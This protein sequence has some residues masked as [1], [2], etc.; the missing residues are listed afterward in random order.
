M[1]KTRIYAMAFA[2]PINV[3]KVLLIMKMAIII[4]ILFCFE[5]SA[6]ASAQTVTL[7]V[8]NAPLK[9]VL[10]RV[11][12]QTNYL[13]MLTSEVE[14]YVKSITIEAKDMPLNLFLT[15]ILGSQSAYY[16]KENTIFIKPDKEK[17]NNVI[18]AQSIIRGRVVDQLGNP[19]PRASVQV[20]ELKTVTL[21]D[22]NGN[23]TIQASKGQVLIFSCMGFL[24]KEQKIEK[25]EFLNIEL[26]DNKILLDDVVIV[27][28]GT[29]K[30]SDLT[31]AVSSVKIGDNNENKVV[32][33]PEALLG[34]V[35]GVNILNNTGEPGSGMTFN[36][37]GLTSITGNNQPLIVLDGQ[38][39]ESGLSSTSAGI[40]LDWQSQSPPLDPLASLN[41]SDI[42]SIEILKDASSTAIYGSRGANGVVLITT[43]TGKENGGK[44]RFMYNFRSDIS[45]LPHAIEMADALTY[46]KYRNEAARN[47]GLGSVYSES[48]LTNLDPRYENNNWQ[49][50]VYRTANSQEHQ[51]TAS[52]LIGKSN[53]RVSLDY[54]NNQSILNN[55]GFKKGGVRFNFNRDISKNLSLDFRANLAMTERK[56]GA[57]S[58]TQGVFASSAVIGAIASSPLRLAYKDDGDLDLTF[59]NNPVLVTELLKDIT[60][61]RMAITSLDLSYKITKHLSYK[62]KGAINEITSLRQLYWPRGTF[63]GDEYEGSATR[64]DNLNGNY[65]I[66]N[67]LTY[68]QNF[69]KHKINAVVGYSYQYWYR[70]GS[71]ITST[72]FPSDDLGYENFALAEKQGTYYT[73][74]KNR[75]LQS[76]L[77][78]INYSFDSKYLLTL[79]GRSDGATRLAPGNK[80]HF[81]PSIGLGWNLAREKFFKKVVPAIN[82]L[83][84]RASYGI[85]GSENIGIGATQANYSIDY[86]TIG[87]RIL[88]GLNYSSF[89]NNLLTWETTSSIN[90][91]F[92]LG[93]WNDKVTFS[94]DYYFKR[95]TNL[96][97]G[98]SIPASSTF[99][100]YS[101]NTGEVTNKGLDLEASV[102]ILKRKNLDWSFFANASFNRNNVVSMGTTD[103]IYGGNYLNGG[104][105]FLNQSLQVAKVGEQISSFWAY[106]SAGVYQNPLEIL[107]DPNI[108]NDPNKSTYRPGDVRFL[109]INGDGKINEDD[110]TIVGKPNP[111]FSIGFGSNLNYKQFNFAFTFIGS[112]GNELI[113]LNQWMIG[114]LTNLGTYNVSMDAWNNRWQGEGTSNKYP[115]PNQDATRFGNKFP[116]YMIEDASFLRLQNVVMGYTFKT[117][118]IAKGSTIKAYVS[119]TNLFTIT[120]Y[121]GYDPSINSQGNFALMSGLDYGTLPQ[122]RTFSFGLILSY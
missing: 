22:M 45:S 65:L 97:I 66:D 35:S 33:V 116:D 105:N 40:S 104:N 71:S 85:A 13:I 122:A 18:M 63:Q 44:D 50:Q 32:S 26:K 46:M 76:V 64:A 57:Q 79:T 11:K 81:F 43:K 8:K 24:S 117:N 42:E 90:A 120:N 119:G 111:D 109:D 93:F 74:N 114:S 4:I 96:L 95:T 28:Y 25:E 101:T 113:N 58:N 47:N 49:D 59:A 19:I 67:L 37:R 34:R 83:K 69:N 53:Y 100:S 20:K 110:K 5:L 27:G 61:S 118:K 70:K 23:F 86:V 91:G 72:G 17:A 10:E 14:E 16:I 99:R 112:F 41:P 87:D 30:K 55:A 115:R 80:W 7:S 121:T 15:K 6:E 107:N 103:M 51:L 84:F 3:N 68:N 12:K 38:P 56:Y 48:Q 98:L 9:G 102:Q 94:A 108:A 92:D 62:L 89:A 78:R 60:E 88:P 75:A 29:I 2:M 21:T 1:K 52:G 36:I 73:T 39:I 106:K 54:G 31:G 82:N 77:G